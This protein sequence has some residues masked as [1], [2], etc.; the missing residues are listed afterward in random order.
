MAGEAPWCVCSGRADHDGFWLRVVRGNYTTGI[1]SQSYGQ[2]RRPLQIRGRGQSEEKGGPHQPGTAAGPARSE[3]EQLQLNGHRR[4]GLRF[5]R[6]L[7]STRS[8]A[9]ATWSLYRGLDQPEI[10]RLCERLVVCVS[11][12][13]SAV[14]FSRRSPVRSALT[15][16]SLFW[17]LANV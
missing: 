13:L 5:S 4:P 2:G 3:G 11:C 7:S 17:R 9:C 10:N 1:N 8:G 14:R 16:L 6:L 15:Y 12:S